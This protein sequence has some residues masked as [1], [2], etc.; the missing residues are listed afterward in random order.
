[1]KTLLLPLLLVTCAL[2]AVHAE[3]MLEDN[4]EGYSAGDSILKRSGD[5]VWRPGGY[6]AIDTP[7]QALAQPGV[8]ANTTMTVVITP[9]T[10]SGASPAAGMHLHTTFAE[11][12]GTVRI[13]L[14][15][16]PEEGP[17]MVM[18]RPPEATGSQALAQLR[19][20]DSKDGTLIA[21]YGEGEE[22]RRSRR[23]GNVQTKQWYRVVFTLHLDAAE[24]VYDIEVSDLATG[25]SVAT[26]KGLPLCEP[27]P[28]AGGLLFGAVGSGK[29]RAAWDNVKVETVE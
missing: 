5:V 9:E 18:I 24:P 16:Y 6:R 1:M 22:T 2:P 28:T 25:A 26:T 23:F 7:G 13:S 19:L 8:D 27:F 15:V 11:V 14:D 4:F 12:G 17:G 29:T 21:Y 3:V 10:E 20:N